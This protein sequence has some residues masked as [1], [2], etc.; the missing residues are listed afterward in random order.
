M[1]PDECSAMMHMGVMAHYLE[2]STYPDGGSG[3]IPRKLNS[4]ILQAGGRSFVQVLAVSSR[5]MDAVH[6]MQSSDSTSVALQLRCVCLTRCAFGFLSLQAHV[7][8]LIQRPDGS[9]GGVRV[10]GMEARTDAQFH[11]PCVFCR[12]MSKPLF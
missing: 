2:G 1:R 3:A 10:N 4:V 6:E 7:E 8:S 9:C 5:S 11:V 12:T